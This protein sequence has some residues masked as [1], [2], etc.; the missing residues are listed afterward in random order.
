MSVAVGGPLI[1][2]LYEYDRLCFEERDREEWDKALVGSWSIS[3]QMDETGEMRGIGVT[4]WAAGVGYIYSSAVHPD[5]Q[6]RG[7]GTKLVAT[8][9][10]FLAKQCKVIQAHTRVENIAS[11]RTFE[12]CGFT[13]VQYIPD[14]YDDYGDGILWEKRI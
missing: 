13:A 7:I 9:T 11:Q 8:M 12:K 5:Y 1:D 2:S 3:T 14:F 10:E 4:K 6:G